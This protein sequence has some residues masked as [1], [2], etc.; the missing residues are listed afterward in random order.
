VDVFAITLKKRKSPITPKNSN[1]KLQP[2]QK[3]NR[4][5]QD[6]FAI[7]VGPVVDN[8]DE[9]IGKRRGYIVSRGLPGWS[10]QT[11]FGQTR[12]HKGRSF[13]GPFIVIKRTSRMG[14]SQRAIATI[15][16]TPNPI[17]VDNHLIIL[18]PKSGNMIDCEKMI[19]NLKDKK[20]D[21]WLNKEIRCRHLTVKIVSKIPIWQ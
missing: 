12:N 7:C 4:T 11:K 3:V 21:Y 20:T 2:I 1:N 16:N 9:H 13:Q 5:I 8:R 18:I 10:V 6:C 15:I 19:A 17:Y 14:D